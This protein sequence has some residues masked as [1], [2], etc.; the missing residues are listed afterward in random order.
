MVGVAGQVQDVF[1]FF[2]VRKISMSKL[3]DLRC[4]DRGLEVSIA[5]VGGGLGTIRY[6]SLS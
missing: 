6:F 5:I 3:E 4:H 2:L 1:F